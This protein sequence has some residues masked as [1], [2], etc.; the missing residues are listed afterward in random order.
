MPIFWFSF[1]ASVWT[2]RVNWQDHQHTGKIRRGSEIPEARKNAPGSRCEVLWP[3]VRFTEADLVHTTPLEFE[4]EAFT[5][6][7]HQRF[8]SS[9][10]RGKLKRNN[11][12]PFWICGWEKLGQGNHVTIVMSS[13]HS[14]KP[15]F[16]NVFRPHG[17]RFQLPPVWRAFSKSFVFVMD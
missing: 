2:R 11:H 16:Q 13:S 15:R 10:R 12:R 14:K 1:Q 9:L 8:A 17:R 7:T 5:L 4:D 3:Q 6:K